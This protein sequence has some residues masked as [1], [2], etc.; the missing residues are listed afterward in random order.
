M[1]LIKRIERRV[2]STERRRA[3]GRVIETTTSN[4]VSGV[5]GATPIAEQS[6]VSDHVAAPGEH[7]TSFIM[8]RVRSMDTKP[9]TMRGGGDYL[10]G[11]SLPGIC[12]RKE[13]L[14]RLANDLR[15]VTPNPA[16]RIV[17]ALGRAAE[18]H[19]RTQFVESQ[20]RHDIIG[21]WSCLC[22]E[23]KHSGR[24]NRALRCPRCS[25]L[26]DNYNELTLWDHNAKIV[27][28]PDLLYIRPDDQ[29]IRV[30]EIKSINKKEFDAL[31]AP[32]IDHVIQASIYQRLLEMNDDDADT[33]AVTIF[34]VCKDYAF[35]PYK[36]FHVVTTPQIRLMLDDMWANAYDI[37]TWKAQRASGVMTPLP[38]RQ[39]LCSSSQATKAKNCERCAACFARD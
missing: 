5:A 25:T 35:K 19:V 22:G 13:A 10:H 30:V 24:Y 26:A 37:A 27:G 29:S 8:D 33:S 31:A 20:R 32:K 36:E 2:R 23:L 3:S 12:S 21:T 34:Y 38:E 9:E 11:S 7:H 28:N 16:D 17:W 15:T 1:S 6:E 4:V 39:A 18:T 14:S